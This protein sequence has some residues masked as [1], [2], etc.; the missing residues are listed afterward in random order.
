MWF[1]S[2]ILPEAL[3]TNCARC[4]EKQ[5]TVALRTIKRLRKEYPK[6]WIQL[7]DLWDPTGEY[8]QKFED[9]FNKN[10]AGTTEAP[11][12]TTIPSLDNRFGDSSNVEVT[13][14]VSPSTDNKPYPPP[15]VVPIS[16]T[17]TTTSSSTTSTTT[18]STTTT[19]T[20]N[21][22]STSTIGATIIKAVEVT[23][24]NFV[25]VTN[26]PFTDFYGVNAIPNPINTVS[27]GPK[28]AVKGLVRSLGSIGSKV[29]Q[30]G[31]RIAGM[32][33]STVQTVVGH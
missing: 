21:T 8:I 23:Q 13:N 27:I 19:S 20:T 7:S 24:K 31:S 11:I 30:A 12:A 22:P 5:K 15:A 2:G 16:T 33:I 9:S 26:R 3:H 18:A 14:N 32:L 29:I 1:I 6:V 10:K 28:V 17:T 4:T 25:R